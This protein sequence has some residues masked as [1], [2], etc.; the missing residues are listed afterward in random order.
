[1]TLYNVTELS[2]PP[3]Y[4]LGLT[5]VQATLNE[6]GQYTPTASLNQADVRIVCDNG[7]FSFLVRRMGWLFVDG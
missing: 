5:N 3:F 2:S 1:M 7:K 4:L 6:I